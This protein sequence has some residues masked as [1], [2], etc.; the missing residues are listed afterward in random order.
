VDRSNP[1]DED[2]CPVCGDWPKA[3]RPAMRGLISSIP[4]QEEICGHCL[5]AFVANFVA[6]PQP[7]PGRVRRTRH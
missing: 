3:E 2:D 4:L 7:Q 6:E 1:I 5:T